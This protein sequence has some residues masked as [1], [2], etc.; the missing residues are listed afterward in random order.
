MTFYNPQF[1]HVGSGENSAHFMGFAMICI[2][3]ES[4][5]VLGAR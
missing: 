3:K 1:S 5:E 2:S 4:G